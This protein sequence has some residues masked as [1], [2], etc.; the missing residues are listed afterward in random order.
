[1]KN[2]LADVVAGYKTSGA[3]RIAAR[4]KWSLPTI[5]PS[6]MLYVHYKKVFTLKNVTQ[7]LGMRH[8]SVPPFIAHENDK[9]RVVFS[10]AVEVEV[11]EDAQVV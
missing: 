10:C 11:L 6:Q 5:E 8:A 3:A 2:L 1:M 4:A 7:H 9:D